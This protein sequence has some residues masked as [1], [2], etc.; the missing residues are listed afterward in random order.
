MLHGRKSGILHGDNLREN[1]KNPRFYL[2]NVDNCE[3]TDLPFSDFS[4]GSS[5][6]SDAKYGAAQSMLYCQGGGRPLY[7]EDGVG[8]QPA[9]EDGQKRS[10]QLCDRKRGAVSSFDIQNGRGV[11]M[12]MR[13]L[14]HGGTLQPGFRERGGEEAHRIQRPVSGQPRGDFPGGIRY[15]GKN[16][17]T[18]EGYVIHPLGYE[19][20]KKYP[21]VLEIHGGPKACP[22]AYSSTRCSAWH[23]TGIL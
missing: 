23:R 4:V 14:L 16:G 11:M 10:D 1:G 6:G 5:V 2:V 19:P 18:M 15:E 22:A 12:A 9:G 7:A 3:R 8:Q 20:G 21:A 17:Y 13:G